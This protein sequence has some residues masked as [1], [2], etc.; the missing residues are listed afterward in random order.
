MMRF[1]L[2]LAPMLSAAAADPAQMTR[3]LEEVGRIASVMVDGDVCDRIV[4][5]RAVEKML[6]EDPRDR[7]AGADNYDV[8]D[9]AFI[10]TKKVLQRLSLLV[11]FPCDVNLWMPVK[12]NPPQ[13]HIVIRNKYEMSQFWPWGALLQKMIPAMQ[14]VL[15]TGQRI[16][17][18]EKPGWISVLAPVRNSLGDTVGLVEVVSRSNPDPR[19][20]VK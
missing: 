19:E 9:Q 6:K 16:T 15:E 10:Q 3:D 8:N 4:T 14:K 20:N 5:P 12:T 2:L 18:R 13:I 17:V 11:D 7:W 1:F